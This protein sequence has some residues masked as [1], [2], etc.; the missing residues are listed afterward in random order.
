MCL[1]SGC[2]TFRVELKTPEKPEEEGIIF[3]D[4]T[5]NQ[6]VREG[7]FTFEEEVLKDFLIH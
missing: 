3:R 4:D 6:R 5:F 1:P 7:D 2:S